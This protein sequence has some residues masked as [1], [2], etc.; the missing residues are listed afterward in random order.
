[1]SNAMAVTDD[2]FET[3]IEQHEGLAVVDFWAAWCGPCRMIAPIVEQLATDFDGKAKVVKLDV[4][5][6]QRTAAR[7]GI[8]SI[9][10]VL[11]FKGGQG[12]GHGR[13]RAAEGG[14]GS[15]VQ[16][17]RLKT[18]N[19]VARAVGAP[20]RRPAGA[21]GRLPPSLPGT[22]CA[23]VRRSAGTRL[24]ATEPPRGRLL[25]LLAGTLKR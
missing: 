25:R 22:R 18:G 16:A 7:Y 3:E 11:F 9:P 4:D 23:A 13:R 24:L 1:M 2:N 15:Q 21:P 8:R 19:A 20:R 12:R 17:A 5:A 10:Q 6:N 14:A